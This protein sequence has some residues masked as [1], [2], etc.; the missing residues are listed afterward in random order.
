MWDWDGDQD[1]EGLTRTLV[2][3]DSMVQ[4]TLGLSDLMMDPGPDATAYSSAHA[5]P[6]EKAQEKE[7]FKP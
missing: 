7:R 4:R 1:P 6:W 2:S 5:Q 3:L